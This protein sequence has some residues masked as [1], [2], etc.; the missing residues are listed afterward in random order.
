MNRDEQEM[1]LWRRVFDRWYSREDYESDTCGNIADVAVAEFRKR[2]PVEPA[3]SA[4]AWYGE[5]PF[6]DDGTVH[7]CWMQGED[8]PVLVARVY[9]RLEYRAIEDPRWKPLAGRRVCPITKPPEPPQ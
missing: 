7:S 9:D 3:A 6:V 5:P 8:Y 1:A 2:Y 4:P